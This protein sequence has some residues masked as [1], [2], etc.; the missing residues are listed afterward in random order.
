MFKYL[1]FDE[2]ITYYNKKDSLNNLID[3][4]IQD[5][6]FHLDLLFKYT[7]IYYS[8]TFN[9]YDILNTTMI[10]SF[11]INDKPINI[12]LYNKNKKFNIKYFSID[13]YSIYLNLLRRNNLI[14][15][16]T[17]KKLEITYYKIEPLYNI[18]YKS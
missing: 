14:N 15:D 8:D 4:D 3:F 17:I 2:I 7:K 10:I 5:V 9:I 13:N 18:I 11:K 16:K 12:K 6:N 1:W